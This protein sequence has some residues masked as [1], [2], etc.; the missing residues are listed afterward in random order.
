[1]ERSCSV[2]RVFTRGDSGGN[3]LG[4]VADIT[5]LDG[6][7]MQ[8]IAA[9]LGFS[10]TIFISDPASAAPAVRIF[11][12]V[13]EL[14]W[15]GHPLVG[16][17]WV[18]TTAASSP[19]TSLRCGIGEVDIRVDGELIW[20]D[21]PMSGVAVP[22]DDASSQDDVA[23]F[24]AAAGIDGMVSVARVLLPKAYLIGELESANAVAGLDPNMEALATVFG[25]LVYA[26]DKDRVRARFFAPRTG[27]P[28]DPATGSAAVA[29]AAVLQARGEATGRL[30]IHQGEEIGH[31]SAIAL[32]WAED[33]A[34]IGGTVRFDEIRTLAD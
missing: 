8:R 3:H 20:I 11:T 30:T 13:D 22:A 15:A 18:L 4:V 6:E 27:V 34:S 16:A 21:V 1:M 28:E 9:D 19:A 32:E 31:P 5:G 12:P 33:T 25:T 2:V 7:T 17:A 29:L 26:R 23:G 14:P 10:E 24:L